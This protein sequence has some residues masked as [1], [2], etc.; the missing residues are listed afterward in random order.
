MEIDHGTMARRLRT[1]FLLHTWEKYVLSSV[2]IIPLG[3][4]HGDWPAIPD[5]SDAG[6]DSNEKLKCIAAL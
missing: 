2:A 3:R 6:E 4:A 5:F 1:G